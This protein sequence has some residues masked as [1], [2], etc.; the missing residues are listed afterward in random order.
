MI[1]ANVVNILQ[2]L[3]NYWRTVSV[4]MYVSI[5]VILLHILFVLPIYPPA[6]TLKLQTY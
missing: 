5:C 6:H 2:L 4:S 3:V 1:V